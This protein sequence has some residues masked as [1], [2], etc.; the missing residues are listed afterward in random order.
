MIDPAV[1]GDVVVIE[2]GGLIVMVSV[3]ISTAAVG[4]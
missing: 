2:R 1:S 3:A 4:V